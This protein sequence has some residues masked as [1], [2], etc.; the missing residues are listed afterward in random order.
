MKKELW[1]E[2]WKFWKDRNAFELLTV[3]PKD[4][5]TVELP[6]D[7]LIREEQK[8][9]SVNQGRVGFLDGGVYNYYKEL[10]LPEE[11]EGRILLEFGGVFTR[12][13]VYVQTLAQDRD[14]V[15]GS[16]DISR[17]NACLLAQQQAQ[18]EADGHGDLHIERVVHDGLAQL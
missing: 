15:H 5:L 17:L 16:N 11:S 7:A 6:Y 9:D 13:V 4:A 12:T 18:R 1:N 3:V 10:E 14:P 8:E 2:G